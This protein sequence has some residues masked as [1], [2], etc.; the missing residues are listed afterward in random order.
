LET[1]WLRSF[2]TVGAG[3]VAAVPGFVDDGLF[4]DPATGKSS[5]IVAKLMELAEAAD[6][7]RRT[8]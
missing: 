2:F 3:A 8:F 5:G 7:A 6:A 1:A 4:L